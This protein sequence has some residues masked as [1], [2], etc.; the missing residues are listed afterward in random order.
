M[1]YADKPKKL[2]GCKRC[3]VFPGGLLLCRPSFSL[4]NLY[5]LLLYGLGSWYVAPVWA[6]LCGATVWTFFLDMVIMY[7]LGSWYAAIPL[8]ARR[9]RN[10]A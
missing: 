8:L 6:W 3:A 10:A 2:A 4:H 5:S 1:K 7:G 9:N